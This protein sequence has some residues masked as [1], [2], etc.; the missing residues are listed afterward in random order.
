MSTANPN[1]YIQR[2]TVYDNPAINEE[3][4]DAMIASFKK[5][6]IGYRIKGLYTTRAT[7]PYYDMDLLLRWEKDR[8]WFSG[9]PFKVEIEEVNVEAGVF[10]GE[11]VQVTTG[12]DEEEDDIWR[13]WEWPQNGEYYL[14][15]IDASEGRAGSDYQVADIWR[16]SEKGILTPNRVVQAMQFR[17]RLILPGEFI[18]QCLCVATRWGEMLVAYEVNNTCGGT[19]RDRSRNYTNLYTRSRTQKAEVIESELLG[20]H[21]DSQNKPSALE[22]SYTMH[23]A[24]GASKDDF[25]GLRSKQTHEEMTSFEEKIIRDDKTNIAKRVFGAKLGG[26]DDTI[27]TLWI[28]SYIVQMQPELL[29]K[30]IIRPVRAEDQY[31][32]RLEEYAARQAARQKK[33]FTTLQKK[34]S[35]LSLSKNRRHNHGRLNFAGREPDSPHNLPGH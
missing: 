24:W 14:M 6:E 30:C 12:V 20:W 32:S 28:M 23:R 2:V 10:R 33:R 15:T 34:P 3:T 1:Y 17:K 19:L 35:L 29:T 21:T 31:R 5:H 11:L 9:I 25:C 13:L 22:C 18:V 8:E 7:D 26:F 27:T 4:I 16:C